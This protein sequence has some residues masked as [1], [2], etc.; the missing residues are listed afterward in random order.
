MPIMKDKLFTRDNKLSDLIMARPVVLEML[1]R[2]GISLGFGDK[3]IG[4]VCQQSNVDPDFFLL[5]CNV[6]HVDKYDPTPSELKDINMTQLVP[7][8]V[9]SHKYYLEKRL[10]HISQ[11]LGLIAEQLSQPVAAVLL[12]FYEQYT[13]EITQHFR[14]EEELVFPHIAALQA[15]RRGS[16]R[17]V[18]Y[19]EAHN[20]INNK[21]DDLLQILFKYLPANTGGDE[22]M[23]VVHDIL[24]LSLDLRKHTLI[25]EKIL[26]P[27]V[28]TLEK[29]ENAR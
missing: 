18:K 29:N 5:I 1:P 11:H 20:N 14:I 10:P 26:F 25:E 2:M 16:K 13:N 3:T 24:Q 28:R 19:K 4:Q 8:L 6:Y 27:L 12:R 21:L 23:D 17:M 7:Y 15:G 22:T 9:Q